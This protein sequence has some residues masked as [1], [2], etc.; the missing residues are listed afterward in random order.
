MSLKTNILAAALAVSVALLSAWSQSSA[1]NPASAKRVAG[2]AADTGALHD[3][4]YRVDIPANWNGDLVMLL[5]GYEPKG[6]PRQDPWPQNEAAPVFLAHGYAVA[7]SAYASQ[8]WAVTDALA[9]NERLRAYFA[10]KYGKPAHAYLV[11]FSLG[12]FDALVSREKYGANY[13]GALSLCGVNMPAG[14]AFNDA[15]LPALAAFD[16]W[17]PGALGLAPGGLA[18]PASPPMADPEA[19]EAA[20]K[21][22]ES[23]AAILSQRL[24]IPRAALAGAVMLDY[25]VLREMQQRAGGFPLDNRTTVYAGFGDDAAFNKAVRRYAGDAAAMKYLDELPTLTGRIDKPLVIQHNNG[26]PTVPKRFDAIYP[27][28]AAK[29][30]RAANVAVLPPAGDG[31]CGFSP[32]QTAAAFAALTG[33]VGTGQRPAIP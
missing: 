25:M 31:H 29:A 11:G 26:D 24:D 20:L 2:P 32:E 18:D 12:S 30:G 16:L 7:A 3:V 28:L 22:D 8:G 14:T 5:H 9:D 13:S 19:I 27:A 21:T 15:I 4:P 1:K 17:Y 23:K 33:W 10:G 6:M